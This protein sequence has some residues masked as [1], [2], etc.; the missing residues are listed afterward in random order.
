MS[1][2]LAKATQ[3][4]N[5]AR[6]LASLSSQIKDM[7]LEAMAA[8]LE[9]EADRILQ[10]NQKDVDAA[11]AAGRPKAFI[12]RLTLNKKRISDMAEGLRQIK[13]LPD[14]IGETI[15]AWTRPNGL[16]VAQ[17][18]V[19]LGVVG[20]I[21]ESRPNV[22]ADAIG[23]CIKTANAVVLRGG[24]EAIN[25]NQAISSVMARAAC[26]AGIPEGSIQLICDT[27]RKSVIELMQLNGII[28]VLIPRGG[29]GLIRTV[30]E[31]S[32]I[33][34]IE[35]G[36][37]NCHVYVDSECDPE[38][39]VNIVVNAKTQ[40][41]GVCNAAEKLL[42]DKKAAPELLP[43]I[44]QKLREAGVELRGCPEAA[45]YVDGL[46]PA[47][48]EDWYTEY[49]DLIM[50]VKVVDG[51]DEAIS[52]ISKYGTKHSE[53]I[54]T[55]NYFKGRRFTQEVDAA[56]VYVNA[57]TRFTDG[58]EFGFGAEIGISTQ[59]LHARGP[60]GLKELTTIKYVVLGNGQIRK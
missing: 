31:N 38:M 48:E 6:H 8:A 25:S 50:A 58:F 13:A 36:V 47:A 42:I 51:I 14:P 24:S 44:A 28:D 29:A 18:R 17:R 11:T 40:R 34:V 16:E 35:T 4:K 30:V 33:P 59:K 53:A 57:S 27:D 46:I 56:A 12:D 7:A 41:P 43:V 3:A 45:R 5:A 10:E 19:P 54:V 26:K 49:L 15:S 55:T 32:R 22:T 1:E 37:G 21:Y 52:H 2:V 60:M 39:A 23:L 9:S 20:I